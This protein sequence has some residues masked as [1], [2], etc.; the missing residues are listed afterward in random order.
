MNSCHEEDV[1]DRAGIEA[2]DPARS[3]MPILREAWE[4]Q[5]RFQLDS[6]RD[7][8]VRLH[9][10]ERIRGK[11]TSFPLKACDKNMSS[12]PLLAHSFQKN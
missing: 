4:R 5:I 10:E 7:T 11:D 8:V 2:A 3:I 1:S 12:P 9:F 6:G